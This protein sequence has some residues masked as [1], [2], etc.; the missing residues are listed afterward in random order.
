MRRLIVFNSV[1]LDGYFCGAQGDISWAYKNP[2]DAEWNDFVAENARG[3][4]ML[5]FGRNTYELMASYWPTEAAMKTFPAVAER[6]NDLPKV[7]FSRT[8]KRVAWSHTRLVHEDPE[9]E[10]RRLKAEHGPGMAILGSGTITVQLAQAGLIDEYQL[11]VTPV[12]IGS[13]RTLFEGLRGK[14]AL[15]LTRTRGFANGCVLLCYEPVP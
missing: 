13:G 10:V 2:Q 11:V 5:L 8:L 12:A 6:M 4:G 3:G 7:V 9:V 14:L 1:T 15:K